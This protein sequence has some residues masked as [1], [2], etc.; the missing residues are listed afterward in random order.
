MSTPLY[1][2]LPKMDHLLKDPQLSDL[3]RAVL[4]HCARAELDVLRG[5]IGAGT[6]KEIPDVALGVRKRVQ[7]MLDGRIRPVI[8]A[9]G[10]VI[11]TNLGRAPWPAP[12]VEAAVRASGACNVEMDLESGNR[13]GRLEGVRRLLKFLTGCEEALVVNNGAA[14]LMLAV[15]ALAHGREVVTSRGE[16]VEIGG[17][18]RVPDVVRTGGA[19]MREVGTTNRTRVED[20][21]RGIGPQ[22]SAILR[23]HPSNFRITGFVDRPPRSEVVRLARGAGIPFIEDLGS[24]SLDGAWEEPPVREA[25]QE[26]VDVITFSGDK[27]LGG[28]QAGLIVGRATYLDAMRKHPLYR[29]LRVDKVILAAVERTLSLHAAGES[30]PVLSRL[31]M[32]Q[33]DLAIRAKCLS[34]MLAD[35]GAEVAQ[36]EGRC[37]GGALPEM[38]LPTWVVRVPCSRLE[39]A[40]RMLRMGEPSVVARRGGGCLIFDVRTLYDSDLSEV[41]RAARGAVQGTS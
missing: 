9:T 36:D 37:G 17:S 41:A 19:R 12:V 2:S 1:R 26:G 24:G 10:V 4:I 8:N 31:N 16:L 14:A 15:S 21:R 7:E 13:G 40:S 38:V 32:T 23:V 5:G 20:M 34:E 35:C 33:E 30:V 18:F 3:P 29:A 28:P 6:V 39:A 27:L 25:V 11:H 22:T